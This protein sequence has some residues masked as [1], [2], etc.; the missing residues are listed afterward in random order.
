MLMCKYLYIHSVGFPYL[1]IRATA[2]ND[3]KF[4][5]L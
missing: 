4:V 1:N 5:E 2:G 3:T